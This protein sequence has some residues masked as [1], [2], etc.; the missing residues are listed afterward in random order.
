[1]PASFLHLLTRT[2]GT[3]LPVELLS[4]ICQLLPFEDKKSLACVSGVFWR[5]AAPCLWRDIKSLERLVDL[6]L[7]QTA[8]KSMV[9]SLFFTPSSFLLKTGP[10]IRSWDRCLKQG[11]GPHW[12]GLV[13]SCF[14]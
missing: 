2:T 10:V 5:V 14:I 13:L 1:M 6:M 9:V 7:D 11:Y 4:M 12:K 8:V 3:P